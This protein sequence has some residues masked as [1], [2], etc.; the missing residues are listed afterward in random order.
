MRRAAG[1]DKSGWETSAG[2]GQVLGSHTVI[3]PGARLS[4]RQ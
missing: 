2:A 3:A 4:H 1:H